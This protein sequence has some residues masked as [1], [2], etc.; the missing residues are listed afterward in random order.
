MA[1]NILKHKDDIWCP[2]N[3][4]DLKNLKL[5]SWF[6]IKESLHQDVNFIENKYDIDEI[7]EVKYKCNRII[8]KYNR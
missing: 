8:L 2:S 6:T 3:D 4:L 7:K 5:N 1:K